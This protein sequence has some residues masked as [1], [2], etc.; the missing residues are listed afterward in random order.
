MF[1]LTWNLRRGYKRWH[2]QCF[3]ASFK[4]PFALQLGRK[5]IPA[6]RADIVFGSLNLFLAAITDFAAKVA[7]V[8]D[9]FCR[10]LLS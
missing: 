2:H 7:L 8:N 9:H 6:F 3:A 10:A 5:P 4:P 1:C